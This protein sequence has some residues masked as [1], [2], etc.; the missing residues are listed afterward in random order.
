MTEE[1]DL[2]FAP[3]INKHPRKLTLDQIDFYNTN[4]YV[5]PFPVF[6]EDEVAD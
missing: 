4:G 1:R 6:N 3:V 5:G 2:S